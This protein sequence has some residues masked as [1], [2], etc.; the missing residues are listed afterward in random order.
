[1]LSQYSVKIHIFTGVKEEMPDRNRV[2]LNREGLRWLAA[3]CFSSIASFV[4]LFVSAGKLDWVNAWIYVGL[5]SAYL[6]TYTSVCVRLNPEMLNSRGRFSKEGT[7]TF[8][9]V[10]AFLYLPLGFSIVVVCGLDAARYKWSTMPLWLTVLGVVLILPAFAVATWA[11]AVN[12]Y[13]ECSVRIQEDRGQEVIKSGPYKFVRHP[14]YA[15]LAL[16]LFAAPLILGSWWGLAPS[17]V[18]ILIVIARTALEDRT[19]QEELP[20]YREY[21]GQTRCRL[22]P[23]VW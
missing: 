7:K 14:G 12:P 3:Y 11:M 6:I 16:S 21:A 23:L 18:L 17:A 9:K 2:R 13:F 8:D 5:V 20:G 10:Y 1:M 19:L 15:A 22:L 4:V